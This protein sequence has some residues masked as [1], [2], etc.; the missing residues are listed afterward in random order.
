MYIR[1]INKLTFPTNMI[2]SM[3]FD[4]TINTNNITIILMAHNLTNIIIKYILN[5]KYGSYIINIQNI[6]LEN[7][8]EYKQY[9][10]ILTVDR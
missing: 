6:M 10:N 5:V 1:D 2:F 3:K 9:N 7:I 8:D 4:N